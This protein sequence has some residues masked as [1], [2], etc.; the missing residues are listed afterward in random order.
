MNRW[1][2]RKNA[3]VL[4]VWLQDCLG[5]GHIKD[6]FLCLSSLPQKLILKMVYLIFLLLPLYNCPLAVCQ[7]EVL[8]ASSDSLAFCLIYR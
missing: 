7:G 8:M 1:K 4:S 2:A 6:D 3:F 5:E